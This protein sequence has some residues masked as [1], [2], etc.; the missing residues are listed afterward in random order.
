M[1]QIKKQS[2]TPTDWQ[3]WETANAQNLANIIATNQS[4]KDIWS[5]GKLIWGFDFKG[6]LVKEQYFICC[7]CNCRINI[8][9]QTQYEHYQPKSIF[10]DKM[11]AY[12]NLYAA[13]DGGKSDNNYNPRAVHCDAQGAKGDKNPTVINIVSPQ[14]NSIEA[15]FSYG[16]SGNI[17]DNN[18]KARNTITELKLDNIRLKK[19]RKDAIEDYLAINPD[20][21]AADILNPYLD[22]DGNMKLEPH[23]IA[24]FQNL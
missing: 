19:L 24:I 5:S 23:C 3:A 15:A 1:K 10:R 4:A 12:S 11:F 2:T 8:D 18:Q 13:C 17:T 21:E 7:Y 14:D 9:S 16:F 22:L 20:I 6:M